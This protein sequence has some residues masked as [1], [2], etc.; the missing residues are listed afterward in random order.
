MKALTKAA[1]VLRAVSGLLVLAA[2]L[3][4]LPYLLVRF[5]GT[6]LP[7]RLPSLPQLQAFLASPLT[8]S[9]II[10]ALADVIWLLWAVFALSVLIEAAALAL[11][12]TAPRIPGIT[13]VQAIAAALVGATILTSFS[14]VQAAPPAPLH[15][16]L[17][18]Q[19][20]LTTPPHRPT[21]G[22]SRNG[23]MLTA[24]F[25]ADTSRPG[26][27]TRDMEPAARE[28][29]KVYRVVEGDDL[30]DISARFLG[31]PERW[32]EIYD[33]NAGKPQPDGGKLED[34][35]IIKPGWV[36]LLPTLSESRATAA[37][38]EH[39]ARKPA[40]RPQSA[41]RPAAP[42]PRPPVHDT[43]PAPSAS[44]GHT[45]HGDTVTLPS[46]AVIGGSLAAAIAL[47]VTAG[48]IY[49]R[50]WRRPAQ[51]PGTAPAEPSP[52]PA[53]RQVLNSAERDGDD[54][55][56]V[57]DAEG[58]PPRTAPSSETVAAAV[59]DDGTNVDLDLTRAP[60]IGITGPGGDATVRA[61]AVSLLAAR[62]RHQDQVIACG[63]SAIRAL[64]PDGTPLPDVPGL[65]MHQVP[66]EALGSLEAEILHRRRLLDTADISTLNEY[67]T[68]DPDEPLPAIVIIA[69]PGELEVQR[70][71]SMLELGQPLGIAGIL[72]GAWPSGAD[73]EVTEFGQVT[74]VSPQLA[75]LEG[76]RMYQM[77]PE[78]SGEMLAVLA[79]ADGTGMPPP[80]TSRSLSAPGPETTASGEVDLSVLGP[81]RLKAGGDVIAKGMR[82]KAAELLTY[83]AVH[84]D[85]ATTPVLLDAL[86]P[87]TP[88]ERAGPLLHAATTNI[89][90]LLRTATGTPEEA[91]VVR[92]GDQMR[93]DTRLT[94][95]DLWRF[96]SALAAAAGAADDASRRAA[97]EEAAGLWR[98]D[99]SE[100]M[101]PAW[102][103][104]HRETL[105]RDA[106]DALVQLA[107]LCENDEP[108][109]A[110]AV[111]D[112]AIT[113][114]RYQET[115][116][117]RIM[118]IQ[119]ALGRPD[120]ARR[121]YKLLESRLAYIDAE[122]DES[123]AVLLVQILNSSKT[124][125]TL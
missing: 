92:V 83:L 27:A 20:A 48:R 49:R 72:A 122:P 104:E 118:T 40:P 51:V 55:P 111:L 106:V 33:L 38:H 12:R 107:Q 64:S 81:F 30:W 89:R 16:T 3:A 100:G 125:N 1:L 75:E 96:Q 97:L 68:T 10:R 39:P 42:G 58:L 8:D 19:A 54:Q 26:A 85:G 53:L 18:T 95:C 103:E 71:A 28:H 67:R 37:P 86:W 91:F 45:R 119:A 17:T 78:E 36:L 35:D 110:L 105:R 87:D 66:D 112:R 22:I 5:T 84:P 115:L 59:R 114:D 80:Q 124:G 94:G 7:R 65:I 61:L 31:D 69:D 6:P 29:P 98:G 82:R 99:L 2:F 56:G 88:P 109:Y 117:Q 24:G 116:Y 113:V 43:R 52:G 32:H 14:V 41:G 60:G 121:T 34:P 74:H 57:R 123:T 101:E 11:G 62:N 15:T 102:I 21:T 79:T 46:G 70:L 23:A 63:A 4:G 76:A 44:P 90:G 93:I 25:S 77:S 73:C 120:A 50:R 9:A 108:E 47:A 13:R